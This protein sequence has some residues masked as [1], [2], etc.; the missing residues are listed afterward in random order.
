MTEEP[1]LTI[2]IRE[3]GKRYFGLR[4]NVAYD[5]AAGGKTPTIPNWAP[6]TRSRTGVEAHARSRACP[7]GRAPL[8]TTIRA[9][10]GRVHENKLGW[11]KHE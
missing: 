8:A 11:L 10:A 7:P 2:S 4:R 1:S 9:L 6:P 5:A 3:H